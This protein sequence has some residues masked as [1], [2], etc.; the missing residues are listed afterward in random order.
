MPR[1]DVA[2]LL[3]ERLRR[4]DLAREVVLGVGKAGERVGVVLGG[5]L[6]GREAV[7]GVR[8][9]VDGGVDQDGGGTEGGLVGGDEDASDGLIA[10]LVND[11]DGL[12]GA[13]DSHVARLAQH[14]GKRDT[15]SPPSPHGA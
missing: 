1:L 6:P 12:Q 14:H 5:A 8:V 15:H 7:D 9:D 2:H 10:A 11:A 4:P 3:D 13:C